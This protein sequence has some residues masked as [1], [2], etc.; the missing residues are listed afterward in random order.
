MIRKDNPSHPCPNLPGKPA[1]SLI[2]DDAGLEAAADSTSD[3]GDGA[4]SPAIIR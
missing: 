3:Q 1:N 4:V 2:I